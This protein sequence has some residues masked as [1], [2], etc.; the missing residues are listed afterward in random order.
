MKIVRNV[1]P[2]ALWP[3]KH[4]RHGYSYLW[5]CGHVDG[6]PH[7]CPKGPNRA[8]LF[9]APDLRLVRPEWYRAAKFMER[10]GIKGDMEAEEARKIAARRVNPRQV[11]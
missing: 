5:A 10:V 3:T 6:M 7:V 1:E 2:Y 11:A 9:E 4:T 8:T